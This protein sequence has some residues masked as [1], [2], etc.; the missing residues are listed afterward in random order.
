MGKPTL[1]A[2]LQDATGSDLPIQ[3][4]KQWY[5]RRRTTILDEIGPGS[6]GLAVAAALCG[7]VDE[8][9]A[10]VDGG[11]GATVVAVG[12]YGAGQLA[13]FS[14][15]DLMVLHDETDAKGVEARALRLFHL[16]WDCGIELGHSV[17]SV[18]E[19][20]DRMESDPIIA[21]TL[22]LSRPVSGDPMLFQ[23]LQDETVNP[24]FERNAERYVRAKREETDRRHAHYGNS[25]G[26]M[27]PNVKETK[28]GLRDFTLALWLER[29]I[30]GYKTFEEICQAGV[31]SR[32]EMDEAVAAY[33]RLWLFRCAMHNLRGAKTDRF[34]VDLQGEVAQQLGYTDTSEAEAVEAFMKSYYLGAKAIFRFLR[35]VLVRSQDRFEP[36]EHLPMRR[37]L[38]DTLWV[39][40]NRLMPANDFPGYEP[41]R[42][43]IEPFLAVASE[44]YNIGNNLTQAIRDH[45]HLVDDRFRTSP[46]TAQGFLD[47]LS[48]RAGVARALKA[49]HWAGLLSR[50]LPEFGELE[51]LVNYKIFH[52][53]T[54]DEHTLVALERIDDLYASASGAD[55]IKRSVLEEINKPWLLRLAIL[56][57]DAGKSRGP[58]HEERGAVMVHSLALRLGLDKGD[59]L[60]LR[61]LVLNHLLLSKTAGTRDFSEPKVV[62][63]FV[64]AVGDLESLNL[65]YLLTY[66][67]VSAVGRGSWPAWQDAIVTEFYQLCCATLAEPGAVREQ[68][69]D[70][71]ERI[72]GEIKNPQLRTEADEHLAG[73]RDSYIFETIAVDVAAHLALI[74]RAKADGFAVNLRANGGYWDVWIVALDRP[75][76]FAQL[77]GTLTICGLNIVGAQAHTR[78][79]GV[80]IDRFIVEIDPAHVGQAPNRAELE[81]RLK[82]DTAKDAALARK[83]RSYM[84]RIRA[85]AKPLATLRTQ[86]R[87]DSDLSPNFT[88]IDVVTAD[89]PGLLYHL[90][91]CLSG[92][93]LDIGI[94]RV[95]TKS[96]VVTDVFY[97]TDHG[98]KITDEKQIE[99]LRST[100]L[101]VV[102]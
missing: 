44:G 14:D 12:G 28:G 30:D 6:S 91:E 63:G 92:Q 40:G 50:Y 70:A 82:K 2:I 9:V 1:R 15:V 42:A 98:A 101:A 20:L 69:G 62:R 45:L 22:M 19:C 84:R 94:A 29:V 24:Y 52:D 55:A 3:A 7:V 13:P 67:D 59:A 8:L 71:R 95:S 33:D 57:H 93:G 34:D 90:S 38:S 100:L 4:I 25:F 48:G 86:V 11:A 5:D 39:V 96:N 85:G 88:V 83:I 64:E 78:S 66:A 41:D 60:T 77:A 74:V 79:D 99:K 68:A 58:N 46:V 53:Y 72:L 89:R 75:H 49:M 18:S 102:S 87:I 21:T 17:R 37:R 97:V 81:A 80:V 73:M 27:E 32:V 23:R 36:P 56:M 61:N 47:L 76:R 16:L 26:M 54:V 51:C 10:A 31:F 65:L 35:N 43:L